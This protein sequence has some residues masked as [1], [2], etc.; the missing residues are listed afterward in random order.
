MAPRYVFWPASVVLALSLLE[1]LLA[2]VGIAGLLAW[3]VL[4]VRASRSGA[5]D[6]NDW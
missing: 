2:I 3:L 6:R 4:Q 1:P 5:L